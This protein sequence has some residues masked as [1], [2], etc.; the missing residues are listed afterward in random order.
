MVADGIPLGSRPLHGA[1]PQEFSRASEL[2]VAQA[3]RG[4]VEGPTATGFRICLLGRVSVC[5]DG[6]AVPG[7]TPR[8]VQ[9]LLCC[10]LLRR[11]RPQSRDALAGLLWADADPDQARRYLRQVLWQLQ[12]ALDAVTP[13]PCEPLLQVD[14]AGA[15][16]NPAAPLWVDVAVLDSAFERVQG[17]LGRE[18]DAA[19][20]A[21]LREAA[22]LYRGALLLGCYAD[23]CMVERARRERIY[24]ALLDKLM[25]YCQAHG[26]YEAGL[27]YGQQ[28]LREDCCSERTHRR[29]M[30][31]YLLAGDRTAALQQ[32]RRC[33]ASLE[34]EL[35]TEP[36]P[37]TRAL[38]ERIRADE[39]DTPSAST[40]AL[41]E[42]QG[43]L[44]QFLAALADLQVQFRQQIQAVEHLM[45]QPH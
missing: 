17:T 36:S 31:L 29:M 8:K 5:H 24:L 44:E 18:L 16:V 26:E 15:R 38:C 25:D 12:T 10:L 6:A 35:G 39:T 11:D 32:Y 45:R 40:A 42:T 13:A 30:R 21:P 27:L 22:A 2:A 14:S 20:I 3:M 7:L 37:R 41:P 34:K 33:A 43:Q 23:W 9:E 28:I 19:Q 4:A 1:A